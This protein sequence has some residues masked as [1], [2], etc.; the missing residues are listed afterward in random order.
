[1]ERGFRETEEERGCGSDFTTYALL[2]GAAFS[3]TF[4]VV[5]LHLFHRDFVYMSSF[6]EV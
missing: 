6:E 2:G 3:P 5:F 1:M 4:R